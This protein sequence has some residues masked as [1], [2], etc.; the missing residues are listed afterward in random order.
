MTDGINIT[1]PWPLSTDFII[2]L[3]AVIGLFI[4]PGIGGGIGRL[5][6][7]LIFGIQLGSQVYQLAAPR[8]KREKFCRLGL[9]FS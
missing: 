2:F 9:F 3:S 7:Y 4:R 6:N 5:G 8:A 1:Y